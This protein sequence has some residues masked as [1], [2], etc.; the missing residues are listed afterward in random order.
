MPHSL[1]KAQVAARLLDGE[2]HR[3]AAELFTQ[4]IEKDPSNAF[5]YYYRGMAHML[6][7]RAKEAVQVGGQHGACRGA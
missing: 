7:R 4:V 5:H 6:L 1:A 3:E 2:R